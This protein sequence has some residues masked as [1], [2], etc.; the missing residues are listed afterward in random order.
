MTHGGAGGARCG[1]D[2]G[3]PAGDLARAPFHIGFIFPPIR[4]QSPA[5]TDEFN[6]AGIAI[7][8]RDRNELR[9]GNVEATLEW[10]VAEPTD[11][12]KT[13]DPEIF[14]AYVATTHAAILT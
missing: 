14:K 1:L 12:P 10:I 5:S 13:L 3:A 2:Y 11:M 7:N 6:L 8:P 9:P 4:N